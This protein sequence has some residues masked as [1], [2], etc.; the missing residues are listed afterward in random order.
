VHH[1]EKASSASCDILHDTV[2]DIILASDVLTQYAPGFHGFYRALISTTFPWS[3]LEWAELSSLLNPLFATETIE[4][5]NRLL[6]DVLQHHAD[7]PDH[8]R[9][10]QTLLTRYVSRGRPLTGYFIVCCVIEAQ[11]TV[12]AQ[13]LNAPNAQ[14]KIVRTKIQEAEAADQS[15]LAVL[16]S[17]LPVESL[18]L[19]PAVTKAL[20]AA[21]EHAT[22]CFSELLIQIEEM[23]SEPEIDTYAWETMSESLVTHLILTFLLGY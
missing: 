16:R 3:T 4:R 17:P 12:L 21:V 2:P 5:L 7:D 13:S 10:I 6:V 20:E 14:A 1:L 11:W 19:D 22:R 8:L 23:D 18:E 9:T 15:W